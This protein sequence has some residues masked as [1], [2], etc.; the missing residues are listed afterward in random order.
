MHATSLEQLLCS[1]MGRQ[2]KELVCWTKYNIWSEITETE[3]IA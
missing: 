1:Y 3:L 2:E